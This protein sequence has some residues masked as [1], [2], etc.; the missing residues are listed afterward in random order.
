MHG[1][2]FRGDGAKALRAL[3]AGHLAARSA[4]L[5]SKARTHSSTA[6]EPPSGSGRR[7]IMVTSSGVSRV[8]SA[9]S[10]SQPPSVS[11]TDA[12]WQTQSV[13]IAG[14]SSFWVWPPMMRAP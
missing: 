1:A 10:A 8:I 6:F 4:G 5:N 14:V 9:M 13:W 2:S 7:K 12:T 3:A 11:W